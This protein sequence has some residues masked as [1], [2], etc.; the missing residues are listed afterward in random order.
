VRENN[1]YKEN[2]I[3]RENKKVECERRWISKIE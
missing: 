2:K 1:C 3:F